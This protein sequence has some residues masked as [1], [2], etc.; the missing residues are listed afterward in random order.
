MRGI[1]YFVLLTLIISISA[2]VSKRKYGYI[3]DRNNQFEQ[4]LKYKDSI[5][6]SYNSRIYDLEQEIEAF[7][8]VNGGMINS[9]YKSS[10]IEMETHVFKVSDTTRSFVPILTQLAS[11]YIDELEKSPFNATKVTNTLI[12]E[13]V[14]KI[15]LNNSGFSKLISSRPKYETVTYIVYLIYNH[16]NDMIV[17]TFDSM[18]LVSSSSADPKTFLYS[19]RQINQYTQ[20]VNDQLGIIRN[21]ILSNLPYL[22]RIP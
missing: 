3:L 1:Q 9:S 19:D 8:R 17:V 16:S 14:R 5:I 15:V 18:P 4:E 11:Q 22:K 2:C 7:L 6:S 21:N 12:D 20:A 10:I 13:S